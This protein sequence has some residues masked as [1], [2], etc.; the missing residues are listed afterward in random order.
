MREWLTNPEWVER[1]SNSFLVIVTGLGIMV[2][3]RKARPKPEEPKQRLEV[4]GALIDGKDARAL[5]TSIERN[6]AATENA[7]REISRATEQMR[8]LT[9]E[10]IRSQRG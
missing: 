9:T 6:T 7:A 10:L 2:G 8:D 3:W 1:L 4:A 5:T